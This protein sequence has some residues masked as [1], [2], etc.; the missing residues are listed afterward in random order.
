MLQVTLS[1][2]FPFVQPLNAGTLSK[3]K[4]KHHYGHFNTKLTK[5]EYTNQF[6]SQ[7][8]TVG[9]TLKISKLTP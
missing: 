5:D 1:E 4:L 2:F 7:N 8:K 3:I 9:P 6:R